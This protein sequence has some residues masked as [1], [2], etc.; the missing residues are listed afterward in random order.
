M[1]PQSKYLQTTT[2][3]GIHNIVLPLRKGCTDLSRA[4]AR[5]QNQL[6]QMLEAII[7]PKEHELLIRLNVPFSGLV[8]RY[9]G[10]ISQDQNSSHVQDRNSLS[11]VQWTPIGTSHQRALRL[12]HVWDAGF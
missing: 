11:F 8:C 3:N 7:A 6:K 2:G 10:L 5:E 9:L 12:L 1:S 4:F